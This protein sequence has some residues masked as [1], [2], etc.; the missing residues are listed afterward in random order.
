MNPES[1]VNLVVLDSSTSLKIE[2]KFISAHKLFEKRAK[3][4]PNEIAAIF[5]NTKLTYRELDQSSNRVA[6]YLR[7][8]GVQAGTLVGLSLGNSLNLIICILGILKAGGVYLPIEPTYPRDRIDYMLEDAKPTILLT[9]SHIL[10]QFEHFFGKAIQ[11]DM[12]WEEI[13]AFSDGPLEVM[14]EPDHLAYVIYTSGST[15]KPK[16]IMVEHGGFVH[17]AIAHQKF[18]RGKLIGLLSGAISFDVTILI[19]F[20]LLLSGGTVFI[21]VS[22]TIIDPDKFVDYIEKHSINYILCVPS[23]Y[24]MILDKSKILPS[25]KI[26]SLAGETIPSSIV[27]RH[28][29]LAPN[30]ILYN[31]YGPTE[32]AIG[33]TIAKIY[34]PEEKRVYPMSIGKPLPDTQVYILNNNLQPVPSGF[35][36]EI[37]ISGKGIAKGYLNK[38]NLT[39]EKFIPFHSTVLYR[40]GDFGRLLPDGNLEFLGRMDNQVKIRG[41]RVELGEIEHAICQYQKV[42]EAI[43]AVREEPGENK[44]LVAYFTTL[45]KTNISEGLKVHLI[46]L[47][48]KY[49]I[50]SSFV[51]LESFPRTPNGKIDRNALPNLFEKEKIKAEQASSELEQALNEIWKKVLHLKA[52]GN[53]DNF[54]DLGGDSLS[55]AQV[56]TLIETSLAI[57]VP[58]TKL[59]EYPTISQLSHHLNQQ[60]SNKIVSLYEDLSVKKKMAFGRFKMRARR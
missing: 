26:V 39:S 9:E 33:T 12:C 3:Q 11:L 28:P 4:H 57:K 50:P 60:S 30:A 44:H 56:Q 24:S 31:E 27:V 42:N 7:E 1:K 43:I 49:M 52:M 25:L 59:L 10:P 58:V 32:Y 18:Y 17:G 54:F 37:F 40:T 14:I 41:N 21:P 51:Q 19:I 53:H 34:D 46:S 38:P 29:Q 16:G 22:E 6:R 23:L 48:P 35:K 8:K 55:L 2:P 13:S 45:D 5:E 47:L 20:H 36:G 15:G